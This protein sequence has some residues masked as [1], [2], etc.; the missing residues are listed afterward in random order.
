MADP[1]DNVPI[2]E[3]DARPDQSPRRKAHLLS[4]PSMLLTM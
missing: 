4:V 3:V 1:T 2:I